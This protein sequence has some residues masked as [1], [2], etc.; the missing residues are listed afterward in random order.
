MKVS[1]FIVL[2]LRQPGQDVND[3]KHLVENNFNYKS[4]YIVQVQNNK[5]FAPLPP[6]STLGNKF[7]YITPCIYSISCLVLGPHLIPLSPYSPDPGTQASFLFF[8]VVSE[9]LQLC[10]CVRSYFK[11]HLL[12]E[13]ISD[14]IL[15]LRNL[16]VSLRHASLSGLS[17]L[18]M[19]FFIVCFIHKKARP[20]RGRPLCSALLQGT[21]PHQ[22]LWVSI[23]A[24]RYHFGIFLPNANLRWQS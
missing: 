14:H 20:V 8:Q 18:F 7:H 23:H 1:P 9:P 5:L 16:F 13:A 19:S 2:G 4:K 24:T 12:R 22:H 11:S 3:M 15:Y 6:K 17:H 10:P 21:K